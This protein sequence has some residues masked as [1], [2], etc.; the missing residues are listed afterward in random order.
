MLDKPPRHATKQLLTVVMALVLVTSMFAGVAVAQESP[1]E[2]EIAD[3]VYVNDEGD[4][5]LVYEDD[6]TGTGTGEFGVD[7]AEGVVYMMLTDE[8]E[9]DVS[10]AF[11]LWVDTDSVEGSTDV[12]VDRPDEIEEFSMDASGVQTDEESTFDADL[13][14]T[15]DVEDD[16]EAQ[17]FEK[18]TTQ[19]TIE[20][21]VDRFS[22]S[23]EYA[24][25]TDVP[26]EMPTERTDVSLAGTSG[27]Y[28]LEVHDE[29]AL[30]P[31]EV[32][33]WETETDAQETLEQQFGSIAAELGGEAD[34]TIHEH[35]LEEAAS[36]EQILDVD[37][38]I[39]YEGLD[40]LDQELATELANDPEADLTQAEAEAF[41][42]SVFDLEFD[43]IELRHVDDGGTI[44]G[45]WD[46]DIGNMAPLTE[47]S[48]ALMEASDDGELEETGVLDDLRAQIEAQAEADLVQTSEWDGELKQDGPET[49][50]FT[51]TISSDADNWEAY[52]DELEDRGVE[53]E[54]DLTFEGHGETVGDDI[55]LE[56]ELEVGQD[57]LFD[58]ALT[59][60]TQ[61]L[62]D[63]PT[64]GDSELEFW[65]AFDDAG[66]EVAG[67]DVDATDGTMT[68]TAGA[69]FDDLD[70][71]QEALEDEFYGLSV[72]HI[73]GEASEETESTYLYVDGMVDSEPT[74]ADVEAIELVDD[75]T[76][77]HLDATLDDHPRL[78]S[79]AAAEFLGTDEDEEERADD[80]EDEAD[81]TIQGFGVAVAVLALL[82][83]AL[84]QRRN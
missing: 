66:F 2:D 43:P 58:S 19:G 15:V 63:D 18:A 73:Y 32:D 9:D 65:E 14:L 78:D 20:S 3:E 76:A 17:S 16:P 75:E 38:T 23:G 12:A 27:D 49:M 11:D 42:D 33:Q 10:A 28:T 39:E 79:D 47:Q 72:N 37:Y 1:P 5:V 30:M 77:I 57:D 54:F 83:A 8:I 62:E 56:F 35:S 69:E 40:E 4:A 64:V 26:H 50:T 24:L 44:D 80:D 53:Q 13:D 68:V 51:A 81:D 48:V 7:V 31:F 70:A 21:S 6:A 36:G 41:V 67:L 60:I 55:E 29:R 52:V 46:V 59:A 22:T 45:E 84:M 82:T 25:E 61:D 74:E 34:V 71:F